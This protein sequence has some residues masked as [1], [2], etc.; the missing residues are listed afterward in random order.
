LQ[1]KGRKFIG[2]EI[3]DKWVGVVRERLV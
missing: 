1:A 3:D 2:I